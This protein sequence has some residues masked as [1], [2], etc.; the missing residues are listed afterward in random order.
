MGPLVVCCDNR[1]GATQRND[2]ILTFEQK[3]E[4]GNRTRRISRTTSPLA[5]L[6]TPVAL[7]FGMRRP[8]NEAGTTPTTSNAW[9]RIETMR[10]TMF[11][12][13]PTIFSALVDAAG[14]RKVDM[15]SIELCIAGGAPLPVE[16]R[17]RFMDSPLVSAIL[18]VALGGALV[19][20][21]G[22]LIGIS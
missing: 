17:H 22:V 2:K 15:S 19:F 21:A 9:P 14:K 13:V 3:L 8:R 16:V 12:G 7:T 11:P 4:K 1:P 10:P 5:E 20:L 6:P 18:Q